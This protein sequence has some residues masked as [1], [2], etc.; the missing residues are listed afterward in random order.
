MVRKG[1]D[2]IRNRKGYGY[3]QERIW[4]GTG[5]DMVTNRKGYG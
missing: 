4:L 3:E 2:I 5:K 1:K